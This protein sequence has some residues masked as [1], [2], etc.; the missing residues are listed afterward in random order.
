MMGGL[1][2][3]SRQMWEALTFK[4]LKK[5]PA[6]VDNPDPRVDNFLDK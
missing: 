5:F 6:I 4:I 2:R 3:D 1:A